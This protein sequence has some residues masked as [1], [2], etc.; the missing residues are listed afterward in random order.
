MRKVTPTKKCEQVPVFEFF[1]K[2]TYS[3]VSN[4]NTFLK[5][6]QCHVH[7]TSNIWSLY[8]AHTGSVELFGAMAFCAPKQLSACLPNIIP[9]LTEVLTDSHLKVQKAGAHAGSE[10]DCLSHQEPRFKV[11][12]IL[13]SSERT[14]KDNII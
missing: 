7:Q 11:K 14:R 6:I 9:K 12:Y 5:S 10:T 2:F 8:S 4:E 3:S 1:N 13:V